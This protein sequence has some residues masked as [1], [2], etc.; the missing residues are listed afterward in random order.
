MVKRLF[1]VTILLLVVVLSGV[2]FWQNDIQQALDLDSPRLYT[3]QHG[4][5][6]HHVLADIQ[7][8]GWVQSHRISNKLW[9]KLV[10]GNQHIKAG[11][12]QLKPGATLPGIFSQF[13]AGQEHQFSV[14]LIEGL[15]FDQ[16]L[17]ILRSHEYLTDNINDANLQTLK[18][19]W[20]YSPEGGLKKLEGVFLADTYHFTAGTTVTTV[21]QRA[22][23]A[24]HS[25]LG[26]QWP[27]RALTLPYDSAYESLIMAS[28]IEKETALAEERG[29]IAGVFVNRLNENMRLQTDPTVIYGIGREFDGNLTRKHLRTA[30]D[31]N[32][33]VIKGLPPTPIAMAGREA[34]IAALQPASTSALYF[35]SRGDGSHVFSDTLEAHNDAVR[36]Y[37]IK[38]GTK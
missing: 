29:R 1:I 20:Q 31:Y 23:N 25:F 11:T 32:T 18:E 37:Q 7:K 9:L 3:I 33:Y 38:P 5:S 12:Y 34:I 2:I 8:R 24:M 17:D 16:W 14:S 10:F 15:T 22:M 35:V 28:I 4:R 21:L 26:V 30:T 6:G 36:E 27:A 19:A 13:A